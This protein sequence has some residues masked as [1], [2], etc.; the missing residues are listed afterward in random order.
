MACVDRGFVVIAGGGGG[1]PVFNDHDLSKGVEAVV[2]K[3]H[4]SAILAAQL[5]ADMF[6]ISTEVEKVCLDFNKPTQRQLDRM[7]VRDCET[8]LAQGQFPPGNMGP[9]I[10][11]ALMYLQ[12]G[13]KEAIITN[14]EH[15]SDAVQGKG[16]TRISRDVQTA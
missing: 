15:L 5:S 11:A 12:R 14:H 16:G 1:V 4:T 7:T 2:D 9:K 3:D 13:G 8:F 10:A 6:V